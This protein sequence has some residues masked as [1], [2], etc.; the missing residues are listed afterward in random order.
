MSGL[1]DQ[2]R[3]KSTEPPLFFLEKTAIL[4]NFDHLDSEYAQCIYKYVQVISVSYSKSQTM[5]RCESIRMKINHRYTKKNA[6]SQ[7]P[8]HGIFI[9]KSFVI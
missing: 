7:N 8:F 6:D 1:D 9:F 5:L 4:Y 3:A 2:R